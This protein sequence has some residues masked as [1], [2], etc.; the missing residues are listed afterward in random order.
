M[1]ISI[2]IEWLSGD[3]TDVKITNNYYTHKAS[4]IYVP[5]YVK[6]K[7][8]IESKIQFTHHF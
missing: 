3:S 5:T 6:T 2:R 8:K 4:A 7:K 1:F